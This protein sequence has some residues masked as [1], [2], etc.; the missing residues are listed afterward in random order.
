[1]QAQRNSETQPRRPLT[2]HGVAREDMACDSR[3]TI[4]NMRVIYHGTCHSATTT[5]M[6]IHDVV[7]TV[8]ELTVL[9]PNETQPTSPN[10]RNTASMWS[11]HS[12][13]DAHGSQRQTATYFSR[14]TTCEK[15]LRVGHARGP[16]FKTPPR[17]AVNHWVVVGRGAGLSV[18]LGTSTHDRIVGEAN[19]RRTSFRDNI[20][21][22]AT[23][24]AR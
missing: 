14:W 5:F 8:N 9:E 4:L 21:G 2:D 6:A 19:L 23:A 10:A 22:C 13:N 3:K 16:R 18:A 15:R 11:P 20:A 12:S 24:V 17:G 1:M 7:L